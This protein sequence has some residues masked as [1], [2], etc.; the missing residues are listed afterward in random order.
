MT[1]LGSGK[2]KPSEPTCPSSSGPS[3]TVPQS[4]NDCDTYQKSL[5]VKLESLHDE[6]V[7]FNSTQKVNKYI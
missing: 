5:A 4:F 3:V 2:M 1:Q 7:C 6:Y